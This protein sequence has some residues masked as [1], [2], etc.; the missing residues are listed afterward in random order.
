M[1]ER[2]GVRIKRDGAGWK[3]TMGKTYYVESVYF[4]PRLCGMTIFAPNDDG[5]SYKNCATIFEIVSGE[6]YYNNLR[7]RAIGSDMKISA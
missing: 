1:N 2:I 3:F 5:N 4:C 6:T 7:M